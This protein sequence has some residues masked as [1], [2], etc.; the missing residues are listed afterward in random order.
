[1]KKLI[2][3]GILTTALLLTACTSSEVSPGSRQGDYE[4]NDK[5]TE[6][7]RIVK[8]HV[9]SE[10]VDDETGE[11]ITDIDLARLLKSDIV[12]IGEF[13]EN[14]RGGFTHEQFPFSF[15]KLLIKEVLK[16]DIKT[17]KIITVVQEYAVDEHGGLITTGNFTPMNKGDRWIYFLSKFDNAIEYFDGLGYETGL[18]ISKNEQLYI[19]WEQTPH[20]RYPIPDN[21]ILQTMREIIPIVSEREKRGEV[22]RIAE[23]IETSALGILNR[24]EFDFGLYAEILDHFKIEAQDWVNPGRHFD[25]KLVEL[26]ESENAES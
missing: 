3:I 13:I 11:I 14:D 22:N 18:E 2:I 19:G 16:G 8:L 4:N 12:V 10:L 20:G 7:N 6:I 17:D 9:N 26:A 1:M 5:K 21:K 24:S 15:N 25:A 23:K